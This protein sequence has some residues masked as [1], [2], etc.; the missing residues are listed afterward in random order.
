MNQDLLKASVYFYAS[1]VN[2]S[3]TISNIQIE[4][5]STA[6]PYVPYF[7]GGTTTA[8]MLLKVGDYQDQQ[9]IL[10]GD[11]T[12]KVGVKVL[13]GTENWGKSVS[14]PNAYVTEYPTLPNLSPVNPLVTTHF[15][16]TTNSNDLNTE[17][18]I[19]VGTAINLSI[20]TDIATTSVEFKAWL[21]DQY[22]AGTPVIVVYPLA[23]PTTEQVDGQYL[24]T[25][26]GVNTVSSTSSLES[27]TAKITYYE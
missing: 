14:R 16:G 13:D 1:G 22:A 17:G 10:A 20:S 27:V 18:Y 7:N 21:A 5:G 4:E 15:R 25:T 2:T 24:Y 9:E 3:A 8:E 26:D 23:T 19:Y 11:V 12:R 6:T